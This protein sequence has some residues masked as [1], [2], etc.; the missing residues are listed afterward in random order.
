MKIKCAWEHNKNDTILFAVD[1]PGAFTRGE[2]RE[3]ALKKMPDEIQSYCTW[4][5]RSVPEIVTPVITEEKISDLDI[6]DADTDIIF[7]NEKSVLSMSEYEYLK[8]LALKSAEDFLKLYNSVPDKNRGCSYSRK[9]FYGTVPV[10]ASE[11]YDHTKNVNSYYF[12]EIGI[13]VDNNGTILDCRNRGFE[14]LESTDVFLDN[15]VFIGSYNE[16]WSLKKMLR[17]FIWHDRIHAK[18]MYRMTVKIF[19]SGSVENLFCFND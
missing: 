13:D 14:F 18:A 11:M 17:R 3:I 15:A 6:S 16:Q 19:G 1:Y 4:C 2:N 9:T 10:T 7:E 5:K 12:G 8:F